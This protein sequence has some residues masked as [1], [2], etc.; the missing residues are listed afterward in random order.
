METLNK[1]ARIELKKDIKEKAEKQK[2][3]KNQRKTVRLVGERK[4]SNWE[5]TMKHQDNRTQLRIMYA[6]Y[7]VLRGK[8][9]KDV[10]SLKFDNEWE[11]NSFTHEVNKIVDL[12]K[13]I[14]CEEKIAE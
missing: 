11:V 6:A 2:F 14:H 4:M 8:E 7:A 13:M 9:I 5:A 3:Y 1:N 12:Y 10:D